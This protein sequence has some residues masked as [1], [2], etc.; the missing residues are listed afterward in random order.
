MFGTV[1]GT[2]IEAA[3]YGD[4]VY[5]RTKDIKAGVT[6]GTKK[7]ALER[8]SRVPYAHHVWPDMNRRQIYTPYTEKMQEEMAIWRKVDKQW[9]AEPELRD[10][11]SDKK[12]LG[13][14]NAT[15]DA[16]DPEMGGGGAGQ[17]QDPDL[18]DLLIDIHTDLFTGT[19]KEMQSE[20]A[21]ARRMHESLTVGANAKRDEAPLTRFKRAQAAAK[22]VNDLDKE[23]Y[24]LYQDSMKEIANSP[25]GK[26]FQ[27][28]Y[29]PL[30]PENF[31][32][33]IQ[34]SSRQG[35]FQPE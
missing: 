14:P 18:Q 21:R 16:N 17:I 13:D 1:A 6:E 35:A 28:K 8:G 34:V 4:I 31:L 15:D 5:E 10:L 30:T 20:R 9:S 25:S 29:G 7:L 11:M 19:M 3:N 24:N 27:Q 23:M 2:V 22:E 26:V 12:S 33:A 32:K